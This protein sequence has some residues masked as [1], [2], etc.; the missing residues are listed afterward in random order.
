MTEHNPN[1]SPYLTLPV[2]TMAEVIQLGA[3][4]AARAKVAHKNC[5]WCADSP[6]PA[7]KVLNR[8]VICCENP[9]CKIDVQ[10]TGETPEEAWA[11]W[12]AR[13]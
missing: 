2:R 7:A 1:I 12:D 8:Y 6:L 11:I 4:Q 5:P 13:P 9:D 3:A 10:A